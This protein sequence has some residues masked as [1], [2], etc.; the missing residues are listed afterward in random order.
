MKNNRKD[1][2]LQIKN[3]TVMHPHF[4]DAFHGI[5]HLVEQSVN[6]GIPLGGSVVAPSGV[7]KTHLINTIVNKYSQATDLLDPRSA[8]VVVS[9]AAT[10][11]SGS[12]IDRI[13]Q[14][15]GHPP[16]IRTTRLQDLRQ[17]I[18]VK[19]FQER[20]VRLLIIDEFQHLFR[21]N[22]GISSNE[23]TDLLKEIMD[24]AGVPIV[25]FGTDELGDL[26]QLDRQFASRLPAR[27]QMRPFSRGDEWKGFLKTFEGECS[28]IDISI[29]KTLEKQIYQSCSGFL[30][31][32]KF[33]VIAAVET[34]ID[35][36]NPVVNKACFAKAFAKVF[37]VSTIQKN[38]FI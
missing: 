31:T 11:S 29:I 21:G 2:T 3:I 15:L 1:I 10:P 8:V 17:S 19:A 18:L 25:V 23:M 30:R 24:K 26:E 4:K 9:A 35:E 7:G 5:C 20:S 37:G 14:E 38:P 36:D 32:L 22:R 28:L 27:Y 6:S 33:I 34:A 13:L 16:G 12:L